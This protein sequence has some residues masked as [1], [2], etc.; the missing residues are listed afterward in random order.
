[1]D[2]LTRRFGAVVG[3]VGAVV[4]SV[5]V[6]GAAGAVGVGT[7][8][9]VKWYRVVGGAECGAVVLDMLVFCLFCIWLVL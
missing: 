4:G 2:L 8:V 3:A 5:G 9:V 7:V 1:L 6:V